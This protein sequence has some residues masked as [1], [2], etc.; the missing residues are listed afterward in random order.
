MY[1]FLVLVIVLGCWNTVAGSI[2]NL[3]G[4][5]DYRTGV[6]EWFRGIF[7][8]QPQPEL[9]VDAPFGFQAHAMVAMILFALWP[10]GLYAVP[11][12]GDG[13]V[14]TV[15]KLD[16]EA[17]DIAFAWPQFLPDGR[18]FLYQVV[19][20]DTARSGVYVGNLDTHESFRLL[21]GDSAATYA[22]PRHVLYVENNM[23][24]AAEIDNERL[25]LTGRASVVAR[26]VSPPLLGADN[27]MSA[28]GD[29]LA[30]QHGVRKQNLTWFDRAGQNVGTLPLPTT[31][32]IVP[33]LS[34]RRM[35]LSRSASQRGAGA[36][37]RATS[38]RLRATAGGASSRSG[39][40]KWRNRS[41]SP[42]AHAAWRSDSRSRRMT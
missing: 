23:L 14:E 29:L 12:S 41:R 4:E 27:V 26:G 7:L 42:S 15:A 3:N 21:A 11:A 22:A 25:E 20:L 2:L 33:P 40:T 5:Y 35:R 9:M 24:I 31:L 32:L 39:T 8:F 19:S 37:K 36:E 1:L 38:A 34:T 10:S 17:R 30:F 6:S 16:R 18:R 28:A 13:R